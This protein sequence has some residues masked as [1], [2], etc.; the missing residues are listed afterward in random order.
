MLYPR[1]RV[2]TWFPPFFFFDVPAV[3]LLGYW[4]VRKG[5][6]ER[7]AEHLPLFR[8]LAM[9]GIPLGVG[10]GVAGS[11]I[12][13]GQNPALERDPFQIAS[14]LMYIGNL[15]ACLGYVGLIVLMLHSGGAFSRISV[16]APLG[17]MALTNYL[18]HSVVS[19]MFFFGYGLGNWGMGRAMQVGFVFAVIVLQVVFCHWWL[20]RF[21]FGPMEWLWRAITYW[22]L[23]PMRRGDEPVL[24]A[25]AVA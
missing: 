8:K 25:R 6:M 4:F 5:I 11:L 16:L 15:P 20:A 12:A 18:T 1:V 21:R 17:R 10:L 14:G 22:Q 13:T 7:P 9:V 3:F 23:P 24:E 2:H 19:S